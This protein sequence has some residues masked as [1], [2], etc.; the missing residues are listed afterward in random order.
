MERILTSIDVGTSKV[1]T[2][3]VRMVDGHIAEVLGA[4]V[5]PSRGIH[6]AIVR[7]IVQPTEAIR[8]AVRE[9]ERT[10]STKIR[11]AYT[12]ITGHHIQSFN[13]RATV[14]VTRRDHRVTQ[15]DVDRV[16]EDSTH[17]TLP[18]NKRIIH[19]IP[20]QYHV[21][22]ETV[23]GSPV[24]L[25]GYSLGVETCLVT[26]GVTFIQNLVRCIEGAGVDVMDLVLEP[27]ASAEAVLEDSEKEAGVILADIGAGTTDIT[28]FKN[29]AIWHSAALPVGGSLVTRD[30]AM[31][32]GLT[33][34]A[35][36]ELKVKYGSVIRDEEGAPETISLSPDGK[37]G[38]SYQELCYLIEV[39]IEEVIR[40]IL[41]NLPR[42]QWETWEPTALVLCGGTANLPGIEALG[43]DILHMPVRI[44]KPEG[45][46]EGAAILDDPAYATGVGLL[47]WGTRY[48]RS[49]ATTSENVLRRF[50][51]QI[52]RLW[53]TLPRIR[54]SLGRQRTS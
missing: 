15:R 10:S 36:E 17:V 39:R 7:D 30:I 34:N 31:G 48:G 41:L 16:I 54:F 42:D 14:A 22:R 51:S 13:N 46:P 26:A 40:M 49:T 45:L 8:D 52:R 6:K 20:R 43:Q 35:A 32:L 38:V 3:T 12:G 37:H 29:R 23:I 33:F 21:D 2:T 18:Q 28:V 19:V 9:A 24:G 5:V 53:F 11:T 50:F 44:G 4:G 25:H 27:I 1:C 47:L